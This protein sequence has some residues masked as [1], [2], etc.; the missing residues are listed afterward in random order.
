MLGQ[1]NNHH[2]WRE[3]EKTKKNK[4]G[5]LSVCKGESAI[6]GEKKGLLIISFISSLLTVY[7]PNA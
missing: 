2:R 3:E 1:F 6:K 5:D 4:N 7:L